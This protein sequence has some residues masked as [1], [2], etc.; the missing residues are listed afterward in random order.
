[1]AV[2]G[3]SS[4]SQIYTKRQGYEQLRA[5]L[6]NEQASFTSHWRD[7]SDYILPRRSRFYTGDSNRGE[8]K[9]TKIIDS[10][11]TLAARTQRAGMMS[12]ITSPSRPWFRLSLGESSLSENANVKGWINTVTER[13]R[14]VFLKSNLY[15]SLPVVY[16]DMGTFATAAMFIEEDFDS[17]IRTYTFPI[18]S[19]LIGNNERLIAE[20]FMREFRMTVRQIVEKFG[21]SKENPREIDWTN[22]SS[23]VKSLWI[24]NQPEAWIDVIHVITKNNDHDPRKLDSKYKKF[25]SV[26][27]ELG[28]GGTNTQG[29]YS[30]SLPEQKFLS[31]KGYDYFPVLAPRWEVTGED[32]YGT[33][34]PGMTALGDIKQLQVGEKRALQAVEKMINPP[35]VGPTSLRNDKVSLLPGDVTYTDEREGL[36]GL[37]SVH[38]VRFDLNALEAKQQQVRQ[39]ISRAYYE[40][41]FL[42]LAQSDR[43]QITAREVEERH[44]EKLLALGP[45]LEQLNQDL[46]D[47]LIDITFAIMNERGMIPEAPPEMQGMNLKVE[48]ISVMAQAQKLVGLG[49]IERFTGFAGQVA[50]ANPETLDKIDADQLIDVY[51]DL[52]SIPPGIV[53]SDEDVAVIRQQR[54]QAQQQAMQ[55]QQMQMAA[56]S[57]QTLSQTDTQGENGLTDLMRAVRG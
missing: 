42:M 7:L 48:Y 32:I 43:R 27:Y 9:N 46:L 18:G 37:R 26:Y 3:T 40:D 5:Q 33:D 35:L 25:I 8:R 50:K 6:K 20:V 57:A 24:N 10:T 22:I 19:Y 45:V 54:A 49:G 2:A 11:A 15:N 21:R 13:M 30:A 47:P 38:E 23:T 4:G 28:F 39:R 53:R 34:C 41:L 31:E 1:M 12:G 29:F 52:T 56:Q 14:M 36:K 51:S 16:G 55:A 44:E 17:V